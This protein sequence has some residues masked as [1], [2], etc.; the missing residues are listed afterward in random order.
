[1]YQ[2]VIL[3]DELLETHHKD[4]NYPKEIPLMSSTEKLKCRKVKAVLRYY[5]PN[6]NKAFETYAHLLSVSFYPFRNEEELKSP[7]VTGSYRAKLLEPGVINIINRNKATM[8]PFSELV[9][10]ALLSVHSDI[11]SYD[12]FSQQE[13]DEVYEQ[14]SYSVDSLLDNSEDPAEGAALLDEKV[15]APVYSGLS[16]MPDSEL[17]SNVRKLNQKQ[18]Q[19]FDIVHIW[20]INVLK[21]RSLNPHTFEKIK[22]LHV[23][24]TENAGY[25]QSFLMK[26]I[27]QL[28]RKT[29]SYGDVVIEKPFWYMKRFCLWHQQ[30]LL[31]YKWMPQQC[32]L[33]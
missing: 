17:N 12:A 33:L 18:H 24:F 32:T 20:A 7:P 11:H 22:P 6:P 25:G 29:L 4:C 21:S 31:L 8:E 26:V 28:L 5:Q 10:Q 15:Y 9:D 2:P 16:L 19:L 14:M 30:V 1:M 23:F 27:Y 3:D 13:N